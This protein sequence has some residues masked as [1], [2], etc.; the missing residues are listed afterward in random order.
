MSAKSQSQGMGKVGREFSESSGPTSLFKQVTME[1]LPNI[2]TKYSNKIQN[3]KSL[4][5]KLLCYPK[6]THESSF[7]R[8]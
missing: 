1:L 7:L 8:G 5:I 2:A 4:I 3:I 6:F